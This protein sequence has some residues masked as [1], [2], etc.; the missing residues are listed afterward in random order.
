MKKMVEM[1]CCD[2]CGKTLYARPDYLESYPFKDSGGNK[3]EAVFCEDCFNDRVAQCCG[4]GCY[5]RIEDVFS[6]NDFAYNGEDFC[7]Q[8]AEHVIEEKLQEIEV[9]K[10]DLKDARA[11]FERRKAERE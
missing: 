2:V 8:C 4:C 9:L 7:E 1:D 10:A 11:A 5:L 3:I 6:L